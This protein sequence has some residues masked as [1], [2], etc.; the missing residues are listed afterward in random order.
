MSLWRSTSST[1]RPHAPAETGPVSTRISSPPAR[2]RGARREGTT[3]RVQAREVLRDLHRPP[4]RPSTPGPITTPSARSRTTAGISRRGRRPARS[5]ATTAQ[6]AIQNNYG[7]VPAM[8]TPSHRA[9]QVVAH[10]RCGRRGLTPQSLAAGVQVRAGRRAPACRPDL[11]RQSRTAMARS[12]R[13]FSRGRG[14]CCQ[15]AQ[16]RLG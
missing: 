4:A 8:A 2:P 9:L 3:S 13:Q 5:G 14:S 12:N 6:T 1:L 11:L 16:P 15:R 7:A 10:R